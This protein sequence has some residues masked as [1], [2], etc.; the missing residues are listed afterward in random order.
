LEECR[1]LVAELGLDGSFFF[2]GAR[3]DTKPYLADFDVAVIPSV[4][5]DPLPRTVI[6]AMALGKPIVAFAVGGIP[7]LVEDGTSGTLVSGSPP[8]VAG[9]ARAMLRYLRDPG[10]RHRHGAAARAYARA[11]LEARHHARAVEREIVAA[12]R[13]GN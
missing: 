2:P 7:E 10:A 8:D 5:E 11:K 3:P 1:A 4:Y 12:A 13:A 9:L 6:E